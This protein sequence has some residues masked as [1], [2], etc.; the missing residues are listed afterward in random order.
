MW[1]DFRITV[2]GKWVLTGEHAVLRG[3]TAVALPHSEYH[4][5]LQFKSLSEGKVL[6]IKPAD[7]EKMIVE[8]LESVREEWES[9]DRKFLMPSGV[10][11]VES[12]IPIGAGLGSSAALC[13][14]LTR[15]MQAPLSIQETSFFEFATQLE[16]RFHGRSSGMDIAVILAHE[17][18]SYI[19]GRGPKSL[20]VSAL[21]RF[22]FH[23][24]GKRCRTNECIYRVDKLME[25]DPSLGR[26]ID[27]MMGQASRK[28]MEGLIRFDAEK[29][30]LDLV[31]EGMKQGQECF[32]Q[33]QL[34][35]GEAKR[36]EESLYKQGA[37]AVKITGAGGGGMLVALWE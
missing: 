30:G 9:E 27:E 10:L 4:L 25:E 26:K 34:I 3:G 36:L 21:P 7:A 12:S 20:G 31:A 5:T 8:I 28:V 11:T 14:A 17:P 2:P 16:H 18:I 35:P 37:L 6:Q 32:Y 1:A 29:S 23:D 19:R 33:W 13:V 15:W 22:T 24:T